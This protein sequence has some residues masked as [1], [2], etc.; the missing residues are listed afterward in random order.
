MVD[1]MHGVDGLAVSSAYV[2]FPVCCPSV[3]VD[4]WWHHKIR[5]F[6]QVQGAANF[7]V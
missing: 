1:P 7:L 2:H 5:H 6:C 4:S 3:E